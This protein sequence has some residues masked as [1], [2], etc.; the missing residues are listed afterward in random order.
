MTTPAVSFLMTEPL[1]LH[2]LPLTLHN[3]SNQKQLP[4]RKSST[5]GHLI[6]RRANY[7]NSPTP[8]RVW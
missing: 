5:Y 1:Y 2:R 3:L 6:L 8:R 4:T 7:T